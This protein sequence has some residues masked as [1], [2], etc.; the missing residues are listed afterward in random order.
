M[1]TSSPVLDWLLEPDEPS[2]RYGALV[3][4]MHE[5]KDSPR[6]RRAR[7]AIR[8]SERARALL[9]DQRE[10][11]GFGSQTYNKHRGSHWRLV[12]LADLDYP[13]RDGAVKR[14]VD[15]ALPWLLS[16][17]PP[18]I[19]G[20]ARR[21][22]SQQGA[23]VLY[24]TRLGY[25]DDPRVATLVERLLSWQWPDG[26]WNCDQRPEADHSSFNET[27]LPLW[28]LAEYWRL[29]GDAAVKE[30][31]DRGAELLLSHRL[32]R[33]DHATRHP[34]I[35]PGFVKLRYPVHWQYQIL[36][37]CRTL[38]AAG[39]LTDPRA[40][41]ALAL[42]AA[43]Q[44]P[45]GTWAPEMLGS[46]MLTTKPRSGVEVLRWARKGEPCKFLTLNAMRVLRK[47]R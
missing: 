7:G 6:A 20:R 24:C 15:H 3:D 38:D 31:V 9:A 28:G 46:T 12:R 10:D 42:I 41:E 17:D 43:K 44:R 23:A 11:G 37:A 22:A 25:G 35:N 45:D 21:C 26:G 5:P 13:P 18:I 39:K 1:T 16:H 8:R 14:A 32:F 47:A 30:A 19:N 33:R 4:L 34:I 36:D 40:S 27:W 2:V 29:T